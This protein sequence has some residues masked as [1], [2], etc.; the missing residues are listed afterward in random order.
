M[1]EDNEEE[2]GEDRW[3]EERWEG[4]L[5]RSRGGKNTLS[6]LGLTN[7]R[8]WL[9]GSILQI[10]AHLLMMTGDCLIDLEQHLPHSE[11]GAPTAPR[12][13]THEVNRLS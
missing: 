8:G 11:A 7:G 13:A 1:K 10:I 3:E 5:G 12:I 4:R 2:E 6:E 9:S